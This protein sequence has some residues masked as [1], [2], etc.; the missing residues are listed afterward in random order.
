MKAYILVFAGGVEAVFTVRSIS[1]DKVHPTINQEES[2]PECDLDYVPNVA[3]D[4]VVNYA[5]SNSLGFGGHNVSLVFGK[6]KG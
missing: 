1:D 2:D 4:M 5:V 6:F 3:R